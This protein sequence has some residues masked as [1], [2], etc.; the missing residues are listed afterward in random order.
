MERELITEIVKSGTWLY[1]DSV[2]TEVWI[3]KQNFEYH[4]E[5]DYAD[6]PEEVNR[7]GEAFQVIVA[8]NGRKIT[9]GP[10]AFSLVEAVTAAE[11][12]T[13]R[14]ISWDDHI[15]QKLYGGRR[16]STLPMQS[17]LA[18]GADGV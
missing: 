1:D 2:P 4:Y 3:V 17:T 8:R 11:R 13:P 15:L 14:A 7:D 18:E 12:V 9:L 16:Y 5:E 6:G 10:A